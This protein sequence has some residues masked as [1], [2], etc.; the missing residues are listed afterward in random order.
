M[1][2]TK[3]ISKSPGTMDVEYYEYDSPLDRLLE[4][5]LSSDDYDPKAVETF[6]NEIKTYSQD[7]FEASLKDRWKEFNPK[8]FAKKI[9]P[10]LDKAVEENQRCNKQVQEAIAKLKETTIGKL[11]LEEI[12]KK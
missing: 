6:Q 10:M 4:Y 11:Y 5:H 12:A 7:E 2:N 3:I 1:S 9:G 8:E